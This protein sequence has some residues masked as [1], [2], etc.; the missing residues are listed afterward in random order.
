MG[1]GVVVVAPEAAAVV[2]VVD[3]A[4]LVVAAVQ[5]K[6]AHSQLPLLPKRCGMCMVWLACMQRMQLKTP[7]CLASLCVV[8]S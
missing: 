8:P 1:G 7:F 5:N 2:L 3:A 4:V 6:N